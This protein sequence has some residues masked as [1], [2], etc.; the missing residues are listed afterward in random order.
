MNVSGVMAII[1]L[2]KKM[3]QL[4]V[5]LYF[6]ALLDPP[7][8]AQ[9]LVD[10]STAYCNCDLDHIEERIYPAPGDP[11]RMVDLGQVTLA[12]RDD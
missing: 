11:A 9:A 5:L 2:A 4:K 3:T 7:S 12:Y 10:V 8:L 1:A 6:R